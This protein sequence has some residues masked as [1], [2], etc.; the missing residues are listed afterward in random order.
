MSPSL[1]AAYRQ[2]LN[3]TPSLR[4][5]TV[6]AVR[7]VGERERLVGRHHDRR[8]RRAPG[9]E[10]RHP[11]H[12]VDAGAVVALLPA[13]VLRGQLAARLELVGRERGHE[14]RLVF[15]VPAGLAGPELVLLGPPVALD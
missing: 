9:V 7:F 6:P 2:P 11:G 3:G 5:S 8:D 15:P 12:A 14:R 1:G 4:T 10:R 13:V